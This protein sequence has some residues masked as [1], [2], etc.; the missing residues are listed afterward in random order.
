MNGATTD[1]GR[2]H[3]RAPRGE[4]LV[5]PVPHGHWHTTTFLCGLRADRPV[6]PLVPDGA[7]NGAAFLDHV[8][9]MPA[10]TL[11][12]GDI[13]VMDNLGS[14]K[15]A[16][17]LRAIEARGATLL[18][19]PPYSPDHLGQCPKSDRTRLQQGQAPPPHRRGAERGR[20]LADHR[21]PARP[22]QARG[23]CRLLPAL[24]LCTVRPVR[25]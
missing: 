8:E 16:G 15:V 20:P 2:T 5:C 23:M 3:G 4:R 1:M 24:W 10:P 13:V 18:D 9:Q 11:R 14:R 7:I 17:V 19:L 6:A 21:Q 22:L 25:V 12:P